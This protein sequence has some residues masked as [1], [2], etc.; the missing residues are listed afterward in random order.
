MYKCLYIL[1]EKLNKTCAIYK[2]D[3][4]MWRWDILK[5]AS[6]MEAFQQI[7]FWGA[8]KVCLVLSMQITL[9]T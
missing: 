5:I 3:Q 8:R 9:N 1:L 6:I 2:S 4:N 7:K